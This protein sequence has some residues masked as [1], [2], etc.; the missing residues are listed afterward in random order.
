M[1][2]IPGSAS[3]TLATM[4]SAPRSPNTPHPVHQLPYKAAAL[5][6]SSHRRRQP[7]HLQCRTCPLQVSPVWNT[8]LAPGLCSYQSYR[9]RASQ[10]LTMGQCHQGCNT[11]PCT[12]RED[13]PR[14]IPGKMRRPLF[15][16]V[17]FLLLS[18][19]VS[20]NGW[21]LL[22]V[23]QPLPTLE[24]ERFKCY[25]LLPIYMCLLSL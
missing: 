8:R 3:L 12:G 21:S 16:K 11:A 17:R 9:A 24:S 6:V 7:I 13:G 2:T 15:I 18:F 19:L 25:L 4:P 1:K 22:K 5:C 20:H 23:D 10:M 14:S